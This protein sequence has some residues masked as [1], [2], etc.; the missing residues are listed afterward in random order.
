MTERMSSL[1][2]PVSADRLWRAGSLKNTNSVYVCLNGDGGIRA[3]GFRVVRMNFG[4][5]SGTPELDCLAFSSTDLS[6]KQT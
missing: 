1:S 4:M 5:P 6:M 2:D 3:M